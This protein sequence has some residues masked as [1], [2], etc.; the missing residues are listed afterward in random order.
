MKDNLIP[1]Q[2]ER[3]L[4]RDPYT[5]AIVNKNSRDYQSYITRK[6]ANSHNNEKIQTI[7]NELSSLKEDINEIKNLLRSYLK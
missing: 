2:G 7:E 4:F 3:D 5:N 1:V 6:K